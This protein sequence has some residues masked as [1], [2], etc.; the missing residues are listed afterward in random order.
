MSDDES[1]SERH[2]L[3]SKESERG[4]S[5]GHVLDGIMDALL[6]QAVQRQRS[7]DDSD[8]QLKWKRRRAGVSNAASSSSKASARKKSNTSCCCRCMKAVFGSES[9]HSDAEDEEPADAVTAEEKDAELEDVEMALPRQQLCK[10]QSAELRDR[11]MP[12]A[13]LPYDPT[14]EEHHALFAALCNLMDVQGV[15]AKALGFQGENP[16]NDLRGVGMLGALQLL[17]LCERHNRLARALLSLSRGERTGGYAEEDG[18]KT[19]SD[20]FP[21]AATL[22][23]ITR[24]IFTVLAEGDGASSSG[25]QSE[26]KTDSASEAAKSQLATMCNASGSVFDTANNLYAAASFALLNTWFVSLSSQ[27]D[28][29]TSFFCNLL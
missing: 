23:N 13:A 28:E 14:V 2:G 19:A 10:A 8:V 21:L 1:S 12:L 22:L 17:A 15:D 25:A 4:G 29:T 27:V 3:L 20:K 9:D 16:G 6:Q 24:F 5:S 7:K 26:G 18:A 11:L